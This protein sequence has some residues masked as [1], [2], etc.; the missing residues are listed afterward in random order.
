[1]SIIQEK[2]YWCSTNEN[3]KAYPKLNSDIEC[4]VVV[5]GGGIAGCLTAYYLS[6]YN[7]N[8]VL[9]DKNRIA[10]GSTLLSSGIFQYELNK[11]LTELENLISKEQ[12]VRAYKLCQ[13]SIDDM[14][15]ILSNILKPAD[16]QRI[17]SIYFNS[18]KE[19]GLKKEYEYR[20]AAGF[21]VE[22]IDE[23][24]VKSN[25]LGISG[26]A[27]YSKS[28]AV[29]DP[30]KLCHSLMKA[31]TTKGAR[32]YENTTLTSFDFA[33]DRIRVNTKDYHITCKKL[34]FTAGQSSLKLIKEGI[35]KSAPSYTLVTNELRDFKGWYK[36]C[37]LHQIG[38]T[39]F[40]IRTLHNNRILIQM[41]HS[42]ESEKENLNAQVDIL[43]NK[44]RSLL[45]ENLALNPE[46]FWKC[47]Y[48]ETKDG[49]P[50]IGEHPDFPNCYFNL[51]YGGN[52]DTLA[53]A[54]AQIIKDLILYNNNPDAKLFSFNR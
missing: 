13:K 49:L 41:H 29:V 40:N 4:D 14:E 18:A 15:N 47:N 17:D 27:I 51:P 8:T 28:F 33:P 3:Y 19:G 5:A 22:Y 23:E 46:Y 26:D 54:G 35:I 21:P 11:D 52:G 9:I 44:L 50:Y 25:F 20:K 7:V 45:P 2:L 48:T 10:Q 30:L 42:S 34:V 38:E 31:A 36:N 39:C 16:F 12:A 1:M 6:Q 24:L 43:L 37:L 32:V 53:V